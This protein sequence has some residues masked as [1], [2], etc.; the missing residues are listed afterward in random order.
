MGDLEAIRLFEA[1][2]GLAYEWHAVDPGVR[3]Y[4]RLVAASSQ[5]NKPLPP[6]TQLL[7]GQGKSPAGRAG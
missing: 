5:N 2:G 3:N 1:D 6:L 7:S 4:Y